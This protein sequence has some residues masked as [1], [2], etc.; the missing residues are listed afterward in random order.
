MK[1]ERSP[2]G[3][4]RDPTRASRPG[5]WLVVT[6]PLLDGEEIVILRHP[7]F[8]RSA[9]RA[10]PD[11]V[12]YSP[13][14]VDVLQQHRSRPGYEDLFRQ[15]HLLKKT[16]DGVNH[17]DAWGSRGC[18][19][20]HGHDRRRLRLRLRRTRGVSAMKVIFISHPFRGDP[21]GNGERVRRICAGLKEACVP[22]APHLL[23]PAYIDEAT[24]RPLALAHCLRLVAA[25]DEV[26]V[27]GE[28]TEGMAL[29]IAEARR[30]GIPVIYVDDGKRDDPRMP[31]R[32]RSGG[33]G[34]C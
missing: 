15:V 28:A 1:E 3:R 5:G 23:L 7:V 24:E 13:A 32:G 18:A 17:P 4:H 27:Y 8:A 26:R 21:A 20:R 31:S 11:L 6:S 12:I 29:E 2:H 10:K 30:L 25:A 33:E 9:R 16:L 14:E 34:R 19:A 22:L